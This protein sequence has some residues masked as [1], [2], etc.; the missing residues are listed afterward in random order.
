MHTVNLAAIYHINW[1]EYRH[2]LPDG[3]I[4]IRL[5]AGREDWAVATLHIADMY[6]PGSPHKRAEEMPMARMWRDDQFD[7]Y[8][9]IVRRSD[10]RIS[11]FFSLTRD[12]LTVVVDQ[13]GVHTPQQLQAQGML[14]CFPFNF[15]Y[16][17]EPKPDWARGCVGY[18]IF[19][20]R[21]RR[22]GPA[23]KGLQKWGS[24]KVQN[25]YRFGGNLK[26]IRAAVPYLKELGVD[27]V[28]MTPIFVSNTS[29]R[30]N[31]FDYFTVDPLLGTEE[32][33]RALVDT[34]HENGMRILLDGVFNHSG[35]E[36]APFMDAQTRRT[37]SPYYDWFYFT[38]EGPKDYLAFAFAEE[39]PKLNLK[40]RDAQRYFCEVGQYWIDK[41]GIDG[42]RLD[43]SPE[44]W[45]DFW[46]V[47]RKAVLDRNP[48][49]LLVAECWDDSRQCVTLGDMFDSTMHYVLSRAIWGYFA[50]RTIGLAEFDARI[51]R[52]M[53][54]YPHAVQEVL[55]NFLGSHDT[56]RMLTRCGEC[57]WSARA[58]A[59]FQMTH[60]GVPII[61]YGDELGMT[62]G[63]DPFCRHSMPWD[64]VPGS[65]TLG[66]YRRLTALRHSSAALRLGTLRTH[67]VDET[68]GLYAYLRETD[69]ETALCALCTAEAP[70]ETMLPLPGA[71]TGQVEV[72]DRF[73]GETFAVIAGHV[74]LPLSAGRGFVFVVGMDA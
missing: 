55:W 69:G 30:Y 10:A 44:V 20:D 62:G 72:V 7:Y 25:H 21:F 32:D 42:W 17:A 45:P 64:E 8:E 47:F 4:C 60:P 3:R 11:Y 51:N 15:A 67:R 66:Y 40:N 39:M 35:T 73:S 5:R 56:Q 50:D 19:P 52:A 27:M 41:C 36:F 48:D 49:A 58:A 68:T 57:A 6:G 59:F 74:R 63:D 12:G 71:F 61:Y 26:G 22:E 16:P 18:Q 33:L 28:Y 53:M 34:L 37:D 1:L 46:R 29:H 65:E 23:E 24:K 31:T 54:L 9:A 13:D 2:A 14:A 70:G 38:G 43:V